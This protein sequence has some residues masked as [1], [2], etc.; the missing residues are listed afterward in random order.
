MSLPINW[1]QGRKYFCFIGVMGCDGGCE[2]CRCNSRTALFKFLTRLDKNV[3]D[4]SKFKVYAY[5]KRYMGSRSNN[6]S[7]C[8]EVFWF[9]SFNYLLKKVG[10]KWPYHYLKKN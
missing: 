6:D 10:E 8:R 3:V 1:G 2:G 4:F 9:D 7:F 5:F